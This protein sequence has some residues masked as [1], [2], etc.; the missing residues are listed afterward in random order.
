MKTTEKA[1]ALVELFVKALEA[2]K[3]ADPGED[4]GTC[5]FDTPAFRVHRM[6]EK[7]LVEVGERAGVRVSSFPWFGKKW[8]WLHV[9]TFG[10]GNRRTVTMEAA[11]G[12]LQE[13]VESGA[14]PGFKACGYYQMD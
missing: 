13:A 1:D 6:P 12:V 5:N 14:I 11:L 7:L 2:A 3:A 4:G 8:F 9:P 10:Q